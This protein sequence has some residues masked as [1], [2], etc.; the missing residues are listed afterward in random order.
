MRQNGTEK[1]HADYEVF[2]KKAVETRKLTV[3][4]GKKTLIKDICLSVQP[5]K[6][7][8]LIGPNGSGKSTILKSMIHQLKAMAGDVVIY[9]KSMNDMKESE[10]ARQ[11]SMVMTERIKPELMTCKE[12]VATGRYPYTGRFGILTQRDWEIVEES[13]NLVSADEVAN[14]NYLQISDGQKQRVL[15]AR[16]ICQDTRILVLDEPTSYLDMHF[17]LDILSHIR[18]MAR[19]KE[20]AVI[21]SLHELDLAQ[22]I[23]DTIACVKGDTI[24]RIG[25]PE[26]IFSGTYIQD[27][28]DIDARCFQPLL[29]TMH[30]PPNS[31]KPRVF[32]IGGGG[33]GIPFYRRLQRANIP[34]AVGI[35]WENDI[36]YEIAGAVS[37][38]VISEKAFYPIT[39][40]HLIQAKKEIEHCEKCICTL[41]EFGPYNEKNRELR[42][43]AEA[44]GKLESYSSSVKFFL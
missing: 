21:M 42:D 33:T 34:F 43:Y 17:K 2:N 1:E 36:E 39:E 12:V 44:I 19:E 7:L 15:L 31:G 29:A 16:A 13:M 37:N 28:Y 40:Q 6:I 8:T 11:L 3:G 9:G 38:Q 14:Q 20:L 22:M 32:V 10:I 5:G 26:E 4:Y 18:K 23:S 35:L 24:D 41:K 30:M 25:A 27:L